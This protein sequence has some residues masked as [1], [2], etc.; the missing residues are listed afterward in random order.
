[1]CSSIV[2]VEGDCWLIDNCWKMKRWS[3]C[4]CLRNGVKASSTEK[5]PTRVEGKTRKGE[6]PSF[7]FQIP[8]YS[9]LGMHESTQTS[10][11]GH[12]GLADMIWDAVIFCTLLYAFVK[13][14]E[15]S[16]WQ[17]LSKGHNVHHWLNTYTKLEVCN[18]FS[19]SSYWKIWWCDIGFTSSESQPF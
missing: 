10:R 8:P 13:V 16:L 7:P 4:N 9:V 12:L 18:A 2:G 1:M 6:F 15:L 14:S 5:F 11:C 3:Q 19:F 17:G